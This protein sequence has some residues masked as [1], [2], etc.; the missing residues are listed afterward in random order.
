MHFNGREYEVIQSFGKD[1]I[2]VENDHKRSIYIREH[3]PDAEH[4]KNSSFM[5]S[6]KALTG[7][8]PDCIKT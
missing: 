5:Q 3:R 6:G 4:L 2:V 8:L 1:L 7:I